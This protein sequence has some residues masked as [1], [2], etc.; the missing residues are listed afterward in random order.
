M[1]IS[2]F[3]LG[4]LPFLLGVIGL[5]PDIGTNTSLVSAL[6]TGTTYLSTVNQILPVYTIVAILLFDISFETGYLLF[7][8]LNWFLRRFPTQS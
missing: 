4:L 5:L 2:M 7:K 3:M 1:I 8:I 6:A